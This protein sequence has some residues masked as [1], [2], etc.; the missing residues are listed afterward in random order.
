[1]VGEGVCMYV[2]VCP[3]HL[4][5][6]RSLFPSTC[7]IPL[8]PTSHTIFSTPQTQAF[9]VR[10]K[11]GLIYC[12]VELWEGKAS[13]HKVADGMVC[14]PPC[15]WSWC[16]MSP[17]DGDDLSFQGKVLTCAALICIVA[18]VEIKTLDVHQKPWR[19][20][21]PVTRRKRNKER[22]AS[23]SSAALRTVLWLTV[24]SQWPGPTD[25]L[26]L[27]AGSGLD[28]QREHDT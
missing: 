8:S 25:V 11:Q 13:Q 27:S 6:S 7:F 12:T 10:P 16:F 21:S 26:G 24:R 19:P 4:S 3:T 28:Q 2:C 5:S 9:P 15:W 14:Q 17:A 20:N 1:M 23:V 22:R 18:C